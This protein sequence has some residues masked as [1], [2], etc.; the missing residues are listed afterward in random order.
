[1][2]AG[3]QLLSVL[4]RTQAELLKAQM[5]ITGTK[6]NTPSDAPESASMI[7]GVQQQLARREQ[8]QSNLL[9]AEGVLGGVDDALGS[10]TEILR[11]AVKVASSEDGILSDEATREETA[12]TV[13][14]QIRSLMAL[15]NQKYQSVFL[16]GGSGAVTGDAVMDD[17][18]GG[19]VRYLGNDGKLR[20]DVGL[21]DPVVINSNAAEAFGSVSARVRGTV[22]L[23]P[24]VWSGGLDDLNGALGE[25]I[26]RGSV[27]VTVNGCKPRWI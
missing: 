22:D 12:E 20:L 23:N 25:G 9:H 11:E 27:L 10:V 2:L 14:G 15:A 4:R 3:D 18:S 6:V 1:M 8:Q 19:G 24:Y 26:R 16:F 5:E 17:V 7:L 13:A 21:A